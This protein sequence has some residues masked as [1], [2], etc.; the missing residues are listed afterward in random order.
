[1]ACSKRR[2]SDD[3]SGTISAAGAL[4]PPCGVALNTSAH[5]AHFLWNSLALTATASCGLGRGAAMTAGVARNPRLVT[6]AA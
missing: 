3:N 1:M 2:N 6:I 4:K 5:S